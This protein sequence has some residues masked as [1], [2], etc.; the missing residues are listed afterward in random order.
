MREFRFWYKRG[1]SVIV[2]SLVTAM[3]CLAHAA[4]VQQV[5]RL[6]AGPTTVAFGYYW[7]EAKPVLQD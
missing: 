3:V 2:A 5:H 4:P 7:S 1:P 6:E